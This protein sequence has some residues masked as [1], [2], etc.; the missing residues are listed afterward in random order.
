MGWPDGSAWSTR[1]V[2]G[3]A[4]TQRPVNHLSVIFLG[5]VWGGGV[6]Q[7]AQRGGSLGFVSTSIQP[8]S[9]IFWGVISGVAGWLRLVNEVGRWGLFQ[10]PFN[11]YRLYSGGYFWGG[12]VSQ[13]GQRGGSLGFASTSI[14]PLSVIFW[15]GGVT[16]VG[17]GGGSLGLLQLNAQSI[18]YRLYLGGYFW[19]GRVAQHHV[20]H[21]ALRDLI[22]NEVDRWVGFNPIHIIGY[23]HRSQAQNVGF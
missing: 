19:G 23:I 7:V 2:V 10:R 9:V 11:R 12:G 1:W 14:Q 15:G 3:F 21:S 6:A 17:Q 4:S 8:L 22:R 18:I 5:Y 16:Q 13:V 20:E